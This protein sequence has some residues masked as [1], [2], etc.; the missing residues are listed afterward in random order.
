MK[1][2][3]YLY[4]SL[5]LLGLVGCDSESD[6]IP[7]APKPNVY[8][9][10]KSTGMGTNGFMVDMKTYP[11]NKPDSTLTHVQYSMAGDWESTMPMIL[12]KRT[13]IYAAAVF[14]PCGTLHQSLPIGATV[15]VEILVNGVAQRRTFFESTAANAT[16]P[17]INAAM[18]RCTER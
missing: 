1:H 5:L 3:C 8:V 9:H 11:L 16:P 12:D 17:E 10:Y 13:D 14:L 18:L 7:V 15:L 6:P 4:G 2:L